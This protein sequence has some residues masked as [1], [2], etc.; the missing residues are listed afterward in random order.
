MS[1]CIEVLDSFKVKKSICCF[2]VIVLILH[3]L[4]LEVLSSPLSDYKGINNVSNDRCKD[5]EEEVPREQKAY[6]HY[7]EG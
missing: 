3:I 2:L 5:D 7:H 6:N 4:R 1:L